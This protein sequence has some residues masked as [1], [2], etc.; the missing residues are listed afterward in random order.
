MLKQILTVIFIAAAVYVGIK[1]SAYFRKS[2]Q[3]AEQKVEGPPRYAPGKLPGLPAELEPAFEEAEKRGLDG[4]RDFLRQHRSEIEDPRLADIQMDYVVLVG[5]AN[6]AEARRVLADIRPR[7]A[8]TSR[9]Y[10]RFEQLEK[11]YP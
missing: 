8:A 9:A 1:F 4:L 10:K 11:V 2:L 7:L 5:R 3:E 6:P